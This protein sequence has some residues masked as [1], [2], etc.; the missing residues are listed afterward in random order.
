M[1]AG[2]LVEDLWSS[3]VLRDV[4]LMWRQDYVVVMDHVVLH[5]QIF[6]FLMRLSGGK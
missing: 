2:T 6:A 5:V 1:F 4:I 3:A